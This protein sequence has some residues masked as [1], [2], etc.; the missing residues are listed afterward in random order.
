MSRR[1][2]A[3]NEVIIREGEGGDNLYVIQNGVFEAVKGSGDD[4]KLLFKYE[5]AGAFGELALMYNCRRA[6]TVRALTEGVV[7]A[8]NRTTFRSIVLAGR[9]QRRARYEKVL[10]DMEIFRSLSAANRSSIA[11]CLVSETYEAGA[12]ILREGAPVQTDSRFFI[13][14]DGAVECRKTFEGQKKV[15][16]SMGPGEFFGELALIR[17]NSTR[18]ADCI[19]VR[20]TKV[21]AL[22]RDAFERLMGP[23]EEILAEQITHYDTKNV[24][25]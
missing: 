8:M 17:Q 2:V 22:S 10:G 20:T 1:E 18:A 4:E 24:A 12:L 3:P 15:V 14:E 11:D 13:I 21:L 23:V 19:A 6:A 9:V 5:G 7:W 25:M 16:G